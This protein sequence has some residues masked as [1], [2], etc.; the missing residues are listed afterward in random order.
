MLV[1]SAL[2]VSYGQLPGLFLVRGLARY[3]FVCGQVWLRRTGRPVCALPPSASRRLA[4]GTTLGFLTTALWPVLGP[5][6]TTVAGAIAGSAVVFSFVRDWLF[7]TGCLRPESPRCV[8]LEQRLTDIMQ[9]WLPVVLR[10]VTFVTAACV[11]LTTWAL[12]GTATP[13]AP[14]APTLAL[15]AFSRNACRMAMRISPSDPLG[16]EG[17]MIQR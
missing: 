16:P 17:K 7:V 2:A 8:R 9:G 15:V 14:A 13:T 6:T 5:P 10:T 3:V 4:A 12:P 11:M 1:F